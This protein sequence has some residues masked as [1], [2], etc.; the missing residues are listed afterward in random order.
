MKRLAKEDVVQLAALSVAYAGAAHAYNAARGAESASA[1]NA[2]RDAVE[3][4]RER[5]Y[6]AQEAY[7]EGRSERWQG[8]NAGGDYS[9]WMS[10]WS[11]PVGEAVDAEHG[12]A[13]AGDVDVLI[14]AVDFEFP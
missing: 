7:F 2:S 5:I 10:W 11:Y 3:A 9:S 12:E 4:F 13:D 1:F 14:P 6:A 8:S